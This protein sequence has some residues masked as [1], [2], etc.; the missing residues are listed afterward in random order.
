MACVV[1]NALCLGTMFPP[2]RATPGME[3]LPRHRSPLADRGVRGGWRIN[4]AH[5]NP[6][7]ATPGSSILDLH[8]SAAPT[9]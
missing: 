2:D 7:V 9:C 1:D 6:I 3:F 4:Y 5:H 8:W